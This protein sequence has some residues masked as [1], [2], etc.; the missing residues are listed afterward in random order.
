MSRH[1]LMWT[2]AIP[3]ASLVAALR[4]VAIIAISFAFEA[5]PIAALMAVVKPECEDACTA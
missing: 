4:I 1:A 2:L 3:E 5:A